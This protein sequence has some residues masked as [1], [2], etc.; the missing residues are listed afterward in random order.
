[1]DGNIKRLHLA[2]GARPQTGA[3]PHVAGACPQVAGARPQ[4]AGAR[5]QEAGARPQVA[6]ARPQVAGA[7]LRAVGAPLLPIAVGAPLPLADGLDTHFKWTIFRF[8]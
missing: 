8:S 5:P 7:R 6:G 2:A 3:R 1:M 4:V